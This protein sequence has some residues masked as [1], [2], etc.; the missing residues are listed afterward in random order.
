MTK[1]LYE[2]SQDITYKH[3]IGY[4]KDNADP[5]SKSRV[6]VEVDGVTTGLDKSKLPWYAIMNPAGGNNNS[7]V[8][9]PS[10]GSRV[11][12]SFPDGDIYN[13]IVQFVLAQNVAS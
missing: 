1:P 6:K 13:G 5:Q 3:F 2:T 9:I 10:N 12:V 11:L 7:S 4:V 8:A